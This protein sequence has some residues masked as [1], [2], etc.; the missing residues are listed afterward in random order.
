[1]EAGGEGEMDTPRD[2]GPRDVGRSCLDN[3]LSAGVII[4][5]LR[6]P[7]L[8]WWKNPPGLCPHVMDTCMG[9]VSSASL[10]VAPHKC[11]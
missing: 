8:F 4:P 6:D 9:S 2:V 7:E 10:K 11:P 1:M 5:K 3:G